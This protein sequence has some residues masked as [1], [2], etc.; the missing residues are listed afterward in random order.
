MNITE[1]MGSRSTWRIKL[2]PEAIR[3]KIDSFPECYLRIRRGQTPP[4]QKKLP[5]HYFQEER[6]QNLRQEDSTVIYSL[7]LRQRTSC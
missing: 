6:L 4:I 7:I 3:G 5:S 2:L 1:F